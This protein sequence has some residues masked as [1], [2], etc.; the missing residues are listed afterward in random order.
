[1]TGLAVCSCCPSSPVARPAS[2][3][4]GHSKWPGCTGSKNLS[5][6][7]E[8]SIYEATTQ[9]SWSLFS[10]TRRND[11]STRIYSNL[12]VIVGPMATWMLIGTM[13]YA[14]SD[15]AS[16]QEENK[17]IARAFYEDLWF[18]RNTEKYSLYMPVLMLHTISE[19]EKTQLSP[20]SSKSILR[21]SFGK[22]ERCR[23]TWISRSQRAI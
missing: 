3:T 18:S 12:K 6:R 1:M 21:I 23:G 20:Q 17:K 15:P 9:I 22:M 13:C 11:M 10:A 7:L 2:T 16:L 5:A 4:N 8:D 14:Q 19:I